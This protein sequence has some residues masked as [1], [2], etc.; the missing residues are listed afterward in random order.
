MANRE[1]KAQVV[2]T[3][4]VDFGA[5]VRKQWGGEWRKPEK[6]Y[7]FSNGRKFEETSEQGGSFY[8]PT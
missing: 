5:Q 2:T 4:K 8:R 7:E 3:R 6:V 1:N